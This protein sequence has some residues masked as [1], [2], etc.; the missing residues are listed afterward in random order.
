MLRTIAYLAVAFFLSNMFLIELAYPQK[1]GFY[2][3]TTL[4]YRNIIS[5]WGVFQGIAFNNILNL[6]ALH[7]LTLT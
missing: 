5:P 4:L 2:C 7:L 6:S 1:L 3:F